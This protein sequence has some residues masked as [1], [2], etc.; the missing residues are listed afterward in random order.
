MNSSLAT[1]KMPPLP[2]GL[3]DSEVRRA[4]DLWKRYRLT[5]E[6][7]QA[8]LEAQDGRCGVCKR[9]FGKGTPCVDHDH[10][11]GRVR[12]LL[13]QRCNRLIHEQAEVYLEAPPA[14]EVLDHVVPRALDE[15]R[16]RTHERAVASRARRR[17]NDRAFLRLLEESQA[18]GQLS[19]G[20]PIALIR[21]R[22]ER[23]ETAVKLAAVYDV[24]Q[25]TVARILEVAE[26][27]TE[28][29]E[30]TTYA[31]RISATGRREVYVNTR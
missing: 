13:H 14:F 24:S 1:A 25:S 17:K 4:K 7:Y 6:Q 29:G 26:I 28:P 8:L 23:G 30:R 11:T 20:S 16:Q 5:W 2:S 22:A 27:S 3:T 12:G 9:R 10:R 31:T 15:R 19:A 18:T 21:H